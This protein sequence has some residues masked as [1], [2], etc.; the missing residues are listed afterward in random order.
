MLPRVANAMGLLVIA[1]M[2][3]IYT[4]W[5]LPSRWFAFAA[6]GVV[7]LFVLGLSNVK[8]AFKSLIRGGYEQDQVWLPLVAVLLACIARMAV[9]VLAMLMAVAQFNFEVARHHS[10]ESLVALVVLTVVFGWL[11]F[12]HKSKPQA[13]ADGR[14]EGDDGSNILGYSTA[15][16]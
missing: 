16:S 10:F 2:A 11:V 1:A 8:R 4:Y 6:L 13:L 9:S 5:H 15:T 7:I 3:G 14:E 12:R